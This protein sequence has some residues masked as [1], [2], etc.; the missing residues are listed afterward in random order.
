MM[1][2]TVTKED[3]FYNLHEWKINVERN[4][5]IPWDGSGSYVYDN[6]KYDYP[7]EHDIFD[8]QN[9]PY[10]AIGVVWFNK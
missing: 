5:F 1:M 2:Q 9:A 8:P 3:D 4:Y 7:D 10:G 6:G